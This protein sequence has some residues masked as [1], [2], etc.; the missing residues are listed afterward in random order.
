MTSDW[1]IGRWGEWTIEMET[2]IV[3]WLDFGQK[4]HLNLIATY[5]HLLKELTME[6]RSNTWY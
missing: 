2:M 6:G 4:R 5:E 1:I 3:V